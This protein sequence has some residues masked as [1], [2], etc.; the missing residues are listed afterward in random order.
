MAKWLDRWQSSESLVLGGLALIV[1][2]SSGAGVWLFQRVYKGL[3]SFSFSN[4]AGIIPKNAGWLIFLIPVVGGLWC[5]FLS[6]WSAT[7]VWLV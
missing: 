6:G 4:L 2:L 7:T 3:F 1:G 5:T